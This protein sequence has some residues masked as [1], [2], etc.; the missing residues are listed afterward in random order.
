[1]EETVTLT[2]KEYKELLGDSMRLSYLNGAGVDNWQGWE[3]AYEQWVEDG[4]ED[5]FGEL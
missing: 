5:E 4:M 3:C 1:M 2:Q